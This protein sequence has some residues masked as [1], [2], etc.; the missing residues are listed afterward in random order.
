MAYNFSFLLSSLVQ[1][2]WRSEEEAAA[3]GGTVAKMIEI[4]L[5][6]RWVPSAT[7]PKEE[8]EERSVKIVCLFQTPK[9][10]DSSLWYIVCCVVCLLSSSLVSV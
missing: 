2:A 9:S 5:E 6:A 3:A 8:L 1:S 7:S 10:H 4:G